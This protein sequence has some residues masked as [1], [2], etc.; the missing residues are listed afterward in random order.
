[1]VC[2]VC[3]ASVKKNAVICDRCSLIAHS[4]CASDAAPTCD[5]R[6]QLL[7]YAQNA[8]KGYSNVFHT[9]QDGA[10]PSSPLAHTTMMASEVSFATPSPRPTADLP[11]S[12]STLPP[13]P[14]AAFKIM[15]GFRR[16]RSSLSVAHP[17]A[18][19]SPTPAANADDKSPGWK[20]SK[21]RQSINSKERPESESSN[22]TD[23]KSINTMDSQ[24]SRQEP[25]QSFFSIMEPDADSMAPTSRR[26]SAGASSSK[27]TSNGGSAFEKVR[28]HVPNISAGDSGQKKRNSDKHSNC[29]LQ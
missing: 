26:A 28:P 4:K 14:P 7:L 23:P 25:R 10:N 13:K 1:M 24:S 29:V 20:T 9:Y 22:N 3:A 18:S 15:S 2:S 12:T 27:I 17:S 6:S 5:F 8:E 11:S 21:L 16:S 19:P